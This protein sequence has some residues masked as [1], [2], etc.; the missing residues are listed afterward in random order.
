MLTRKGVLAV[1]HQPETHKY[2]D[3]DAL[4]GKTQ[5]AASTHDDKRQTTMQLD[6]SSPP[7]VFSPLPHNLPPPE[8]SSN[9][10]NTNPSAADANSKTSTGKARAAGQDKAEPEAV[11]HTPLMELP[12]QAVPT[13][14]INNIFFDALPELDKDETW[15]EAAE[16]PAKPGSRRAH[17]QPA[18]RTVEAEPDANTPPSCQ[19][20]PQVIAQGKKQSKPFTLPPKP[21]A[22]KEPTPW[23][24]STTGK[25]FQH[26]AQSY[27]C[28]QQAQMNHHLTFG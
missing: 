25:L 12:E 9:E 18:E 5:E 22:N 2:S 16:T 7:P 4:P 17:G 6:L 3:F 8:P 26:C 19:L 27:Q 23:Q 28:H 1:R 14:E 24:F 20:A 10:P 13:T 15:H 21:P 11:Q